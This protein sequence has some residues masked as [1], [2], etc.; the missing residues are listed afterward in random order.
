VNR[1][2]AHTGP[3]KGYWPRGGR[4]PLDVDIGA[5]SDAIRDALSGGGETISAVARRFGVSRGWIHANV[6]PALG[7]QSRAK[8]V[9]TPPDP[10]DAGF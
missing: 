10:A 8:S 5:I 2:T 6:Y 4:P 7:Y 9:Q 3:H 1:E